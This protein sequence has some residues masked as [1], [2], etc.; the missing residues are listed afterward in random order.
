MNYKLKVGDYVRTI[1][2]KLSEKD[3]RY[4][5]YQITDRAIDAYREDSYIAIKSKTLKSELF[6]V[7]YAKTV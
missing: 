5:G 2:E 6:K 4:P 3:T 7:M 1:F